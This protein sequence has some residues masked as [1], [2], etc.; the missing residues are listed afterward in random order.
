MIRWDK[1]KGNDKN[2][3]SFIRKTIYSINILF[4]NNKHIFGFTD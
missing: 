2:D 3:I 1:Y 4:S